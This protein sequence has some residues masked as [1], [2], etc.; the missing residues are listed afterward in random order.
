MK[1]GRLGRLLGHLKPVAGGMAPCLSSSPVVAGGTF[2][3]WAENLYT[4]PPPGSPGSG[5]K[6]TA[7]QQ[8]DPPQQV[9]LSLPQPRETWACGVFA[10]GERERHVCSENKLCA[11]AAQGA[12][13]ARH[14]D[15]G[16]DGEGQLLPK[17]QPRT[18]LA[19]LTERHQIV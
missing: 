12:A 3:S 10:P 18:R 16:Q 19:R 5:L 7:T 17:A 9:H 8:E 14:G 1:A 15:S 13:V 6:G 11:L 2:L 4:I